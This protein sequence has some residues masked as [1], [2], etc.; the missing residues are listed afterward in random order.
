MLGAD[1]VIG[2][3]HQRDQVGGDRRGG[4]HLPAAAPG[5]AGQPVPGYGPVARRGYRHGDGR[6]EVRLVE[7]GEDPLG[8]VKA[9]VH[10]QVRLAVG[11]VGEAVHPRAVARVVH[12]RLDPQLIS[13]PQAGQRQP[14]PGQRGRI[15]LLAVEHHPAQPGGPE[16][17]KA[18]R[19]GRSA[20]EPDD[21]D[22]AERVRA[23]G[24]VELDPVAVHVDEPGALPRLPVRQ[25][26]H[27]ASGRSA[28]SGQRPTY[29]VTGPAGRSR[30][31]P[32]L[33]SATNRQPTRPGS[34]RVSETRFE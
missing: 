17:G 31:L 23:A 4:G 5:R 32:G 29:R 11:R 3:R 22:R 12:V 15:H 8:V 24:D 14:V 10:G 7:G 26:R 18:G 25:C 27:P 34:C 13:L 6:L 33:G 16:L 21:G 1:A 20:A 9:G 30:A 2:A 28:R 19:S